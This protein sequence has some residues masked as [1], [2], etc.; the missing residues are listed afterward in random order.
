M[1]AMQSKPTR[2]RWHGLLIALAGLALLLAA[3]FGLR[4]L[5]SVLKDNP[6]LVTG[7]PGDLLYAAGFDGFTDEWATYDGRLSAEISDGTLQISVGVA[8]AGPYVPARWSFADFDV[9]VKARA[10][11]GP[12]NNGF[13]VVFRMRDAGNYYAFLISSDGFYQV[14]RAVDGVSKEVSTWI[15]SDWVNQGMDADNLLRVLAKGDQ[16]SFFING[17]P[18]TLCLPDDPNAQSTYYL[19]ECREGALYDTL[20]DG[21][22]ATGRIGLIAITLDQPDVQVAFDNLTVYQP[23]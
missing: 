2:S 14:V 13:G 22:H 7:E 9:S 3:W 4:Q 10:L 17:E 8:N 23:E 19:G 20:T 6:P 1:P 15:R 21:T 12:D 18:V 11:T 16:F 5:G